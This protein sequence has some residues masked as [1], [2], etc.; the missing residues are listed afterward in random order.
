MI[1]RKKLG[2]T[3][4]VG[5]VFGFGLLFAGT[6]PAAAAPPAHAKAYGYRNQGNHYR[7]GPA[8]GSRYTPYQNGRSQ[9]GWNTRT[10]YGYNASPY[11]YRTSP[12]PPKQDIDR[13][14]IRNRND[15]DID[16]DGVR[17][18]RDDRPANPLVR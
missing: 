13:D 8:Y 6:Q 14:G 11:G 12:L 15:R 3:L 7:Y 17:N 5:T 4:A 9:W 18:K 1:Q 16:G 10:P 2:M